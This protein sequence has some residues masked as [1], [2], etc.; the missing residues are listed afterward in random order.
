VVAVR[1]QNYNRGMYSS[2]QV[3]I[4]ALP[5]N[6]DACFLLPVDTPLVRASTISALAARYQVEPMPVIHPSFAGKHGHPPLIGSELFPDILLGT[7][8]GGLRALLEQRASTQVKVAD[9][10]ILL[11]MDTPADHARL[12]ELAHRRHVPT[13][14]EC[15]AM[16]D[17][18]GVAEP[19]RRH[20][21]AVA[22]VA[23]ALA[24]RLGTIDHDLIVAAGLLHDV[25][26][27]QPDHAF[28]GAVMVA[29]LGF[30]SVAEAMRHHMDYT[31]ANGHLD[32]AAV[33]FVADKLV[34]EDRRVPLASRFEPAMERFAGQPEA[35]AGARRKYDTACK[36]LA[37]IEARAGMSHA[38]MLAGCG[39]PG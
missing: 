39:V 35:L 33:L 6:V 2:V 32:A 8:D 34:R 22:A 18:H 13:V 1:N 5:D 38:Q 28:A 20:S 11:D 29:K 4:D 10:A 9:E 23:A 25:A 15:E 12:A 17:L 31:F 3:G 19:V 30:P 21:R 37:A 24:E 36:V 26:K 7:G 14:A 16:L 27:G